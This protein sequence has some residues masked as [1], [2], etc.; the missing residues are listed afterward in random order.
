VESFPKISEYMDTTVPALTPETRIIEA[1]D[2]LLHHKVTGAPVVDAS[3]K[4]V[5]IITE[6]DLLKLLAEGVRGEPPT[7]ATVAEFMTADVVTVP[8]DVD[9]YYVAGMFLANKF[10]RLLV[11]D[12]GKIVGAI[13]RYD[14]LRVVRKLFDMS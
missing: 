1:V 2:F 7:E 10:R 6:T 5:G 9:I 13:T 14:L 12:G 11:V 8:P 4:P 3:G